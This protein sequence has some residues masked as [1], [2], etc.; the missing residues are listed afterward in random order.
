MCGCETWSLSL[1]EK[2][3]LRV[4]ENRVLRRILGPKRDEVTGK[5][6]ELHN[7]ELNGL[8]SA[9][10]IFRVIKSRRTRWAGH[11]ARVGE[12]R[13]VY[14][15][16]V[17]KHEGKRPLWRHRRRCGENIKMDLQEVCCGCNLVQEIS[18]HIVKSS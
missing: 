13:D 15:F 8:Y 6:R 14:W 12:R 18:F 5:W 3:K 9:L 11:V 2:L 17:G 1:R 10:S 7:E 16:L 4:F